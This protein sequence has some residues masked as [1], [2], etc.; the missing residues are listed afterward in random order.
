LECEVDGK[1]LGR[2]QNALSTEEGALR[3]RVLKRI[4]TG[5]GI[6]KGGWSSHPTVKSR[7][8]SSAGPDFYYNP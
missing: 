2:I 4:S 7:V 5:V 3:S 8:F 6:K 1:R